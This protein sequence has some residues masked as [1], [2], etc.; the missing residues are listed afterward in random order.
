MK[1]LLLPFA[2]FALVGIYSC[3]DD[4][5]KAVIDDEE[6]VAPEITSPTNGFSKVIT[7]EETSNEFTV[8]WSAAEYGVELAVSYNVQ[9]D[10]A[11]NDFAAPG[12]LG[13]TS[14]S[15]LTVTYGELNDFL[16][17]D[18]G[19]TANEEVSLNLRVISTAT[20]QEEL[21]SETIT[22]SITTWQEEDEEPEP[23]D[24]PKLYIA[25]DFQGWD[26]AN[27]STIVS[28]NDDGVYEGY[29]YIPAGGTNEFKLYAQ[30][31]WVPDSYGTTN[32]DSTLFK[33]NYAGDNFMA[34]S[35]GYY[36]FAVNMNDSTYFLMKTDW[37]L[38][39]GATPGGWDTDTEMAFDPETETWSVTADMIA[40][41]SFKFRA[42]KAWQLDFGIDEEGNLVYANHPWKDY[43][44]QPQLSV[45][46][47]GNYTIKLDLHEPGNYTYSIEKN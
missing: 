47:D 24:Y 1:K 45:P 8:A 15:P 38:I 3:E 35:D 28:V 18:L 30:P 22:I 4:E 20:G 2:F 19:Q 27:A 16:I 6:L 17:N 11:G 36:L 9:I 42:N 43:V 44:D 13:A 34:P 26:I 14:Q 31:D 23:V 41:G 12:S 7:E 46:E 25:G 10:V 29:I 39:G 33:A 21:V 5:P 32:E 40:D 37:G